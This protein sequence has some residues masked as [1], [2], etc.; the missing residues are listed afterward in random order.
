MNVSKG[1]LILKMLEKFGT[2]FLIIGLALF[3]C[4][5]SIHYRNGWIFILSLAIPMAVFGVTLLIKD[6]QTLARRL[7][8]KEPDKKQNA[9]ISLSGWM[10]LLSFILSGLD[11]RFG[12]S[13]VPTAVVVAALIVM[14]GGYV[15][16]VWVI[17]Q[18]AYA[19]RVVDVYENQKIITD[20]LYS[21]VRHPMYLA[22]LFI[23]LAMP[24][25]LGSWVALIPMLHYP[26]VLVRRIR[27]EE[28]LLIRELDG[29]DDYI[30]KVK[31]RL[32]PFI[33]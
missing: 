28:T 11:Y 23:F 20:G 13:N 32:V 27:S 6:P 10:F 7:L 12:W 18:N 1:S 3:L 14:L 31:Y 16:F 21:I 19:S 29:Y 8:D 5:G 24:V 33:W 17:L 26:I 22:S 4:A 25:V 9:N 15:M 2:G 30:T